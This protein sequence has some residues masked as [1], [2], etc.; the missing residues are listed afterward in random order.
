[1]FDGT[2]KGPLPAGSVI[3]M[4]YYGI[5]AASN[6]NGRLDGNYGSTTD[7][8]SGV[9]SN[10]EA[11]VA[12]VSHRFARRLQFNVNYTWSHALDYGEN[13]TTFTNQNS[14]MDP[15][16]LRAEYGNSNQNVSNRVSLM[17]CMKRLPV[18]TESLA[19][20]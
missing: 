11:V 20:C 10:Y 16:N 17:E 1:M 4:P 2:G 12:A 19:I 14:L 18:S 9:N 6:S 3:Q 5:G 15:F 13:N 7:I 8:F